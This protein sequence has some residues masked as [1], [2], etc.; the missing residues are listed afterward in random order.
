MQNLA[1]DTEN[2]PLSALAGRSGRTPNKRMTMGGPTMVPYR[3]GPGSPQGSPLANR[4]N[5]GA[6]NS[7]PS[8]PPSYAEPAG[9]GV[10]TRSMGPPPPAAGRPPAARGE[11]SD[12]AGDPWGAGTN[13][14]ADSA[15][16]KAQAQ[17]RRQT[18]YVPGTGSMAPP[19]ATGHQ[20]HR[21]PAGHAHPPYGGRPSTG[22]SSAGP[23][24][25][26]D[27]FHSVPSSPWGSPA[28]A[29]GASA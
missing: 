18:S 21:P 5:F 1:G 26:E 11:V 20:G 3:G 28:R 24:P 23:G 2:V 15:A 9:T 19:F 7:P 10:R 29:T 22:S 6:P 4:S 12:G 16:A 17:R 27:E 14:Q 8:A 25:G 13:W